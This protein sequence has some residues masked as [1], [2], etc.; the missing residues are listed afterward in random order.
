MKGRSSFLMEAG[1]EA[2]ELQDVL[3]R[4][5]LQLETKLN[6]QL[7]RPL[8]AKQ[9]PGGEAK[10]W[11]GSLGWPQKVQFM[12]AWAA[13]DIPSGPKGHLKSPRLWRLMEQLREVVHSEGAGR[14]SVQALHR[15]VDVAENLLVRFQH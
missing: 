5:W 1:D 2:E 13:A 4:R 7:V 11:V 12:K 10:A 15:W 3:A 9:W 6:L 14:Y 8:I